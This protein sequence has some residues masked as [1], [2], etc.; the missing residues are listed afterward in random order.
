[1]KITISGQD[2]TSALDA[3]HPLTIERKLNEPSVCQLWITLSS[4]QPAP[5]IVRNQSI[6]IIGDD[7]SYYFTGYIAASPMPEYAGLGIEGPRYRIAIQAISDEYL[8]DQLMMAPGKGVAGLNAGSL[9][10][11]LV[12]KTGS[13]RARTQALALNSPVSSFI[14]EPGS[15]FSAS[16]GAVANQA[17]AAY[18]ALNGALALSA[19]PAALHPLNETDGSLTLAN[20]TLTAGVKRALANDITVCGEHEPTAYVTEYFLGDG[21]TT[22]F[23]FLATSSLPSS[24]STIIRELFNES[25]DRSARLGQSWKS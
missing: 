4:R 9:V 3:A 16:A 7:G 23:N 11:S 22:Q 25:A 15:S 14:P 18:R 24:K 20:L 19:I 1:M 21:V 8:L 17:R 10:A 5:T 13:I 6:Q 12:T 2:F